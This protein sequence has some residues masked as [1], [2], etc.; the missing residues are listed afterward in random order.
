M[1][2]EMIMISCFTHIPLPW[3]WRQN[4]LS[5]FNCQ[6]LEKILKREKD[7]WVQ[8]SKSAPG[9]ASSGQDTK[10]GGHD[11]TPGAGRA[12]LSSVQSGRSYGSVRGCGGVS[13]GNLTLSKA[14]GGRGKQHSFG[15][16]SDDPAVSGNGSAR[17]R[18][19]FLPKSRVGENAISLLKEKLLSSSC[20]SSEGGED[21]EG[22]EDAGYLLFSCV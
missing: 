8:L 22:G 7:V 10:I 20:S 9:G 15:R 2:S 18:G 19:H 14:G 1:V 5:L 21:V 12:S 11:L 13:S 6:E 16:M 3:N 4:Q 17:K